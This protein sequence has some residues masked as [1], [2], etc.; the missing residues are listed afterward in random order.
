MLFAETELA[1]LLREELVS[2][3]E[4][5]DDEELL[6]AGVEELERLVVTAL[7]VELALETG[8]LSFGLS[9]TK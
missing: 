7:D 6:G 4:L 5:L 8:S 3:T 1:T 2:A 9:P